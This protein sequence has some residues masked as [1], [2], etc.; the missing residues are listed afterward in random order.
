MDRTL[1]CNIQADAG[2]LTTWRVI[3]RKKNNE[4][5]RRALC[6]LNKRYKIIISRYNHQVLIVS[7]HHN[8]SIHNMIYLSLYEHLALK[9][10][11]D[12]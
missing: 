11:P 1:F 7:G 6:G 2:V 10:Y 5:I 8:L 9:Y 4:S 3:V 12:G